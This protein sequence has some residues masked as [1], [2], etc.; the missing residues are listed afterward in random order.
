MFP[1]LIPFKHVNS[2]K[3]SIAIGNILIV[4]IHKYDEILKLLSNES[5]YRTNSLPMHRWQLLKF[6]L[7]ILLKSFKSVNAVDVIV[8]KSSATQMI[9]PWQTGK[10]RITIWIFKDGSMN[11]IS[12]LSVITCKIRFLDLGL[13][14]SN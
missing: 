3:L 1:K 5:L 12:W 14:C 2:N 11:M 6:R 7:I 8:M 10:W 4:K 13:R 9:Y